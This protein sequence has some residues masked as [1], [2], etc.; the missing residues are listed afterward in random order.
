MFD[1]LIGRTSSVTTV[2]IVDDTPTTATVSSNELYAFDDWKT[3]LDAQGIS[4]SFVGQENADVWA[5]FKAVSG[6]GSGSA[7]SRDGTAYGLE[8][9]QVFGN[10][11][12][13]ISAQIS[14]V[15]EGPTGVNFIQQDYQGS[16]C[17]VLNND[18]H[19]TNLLSYNGFGISTQTNPAPNLSY[20]YTGS[21][22]DP[23][24]DAQDDTPAGST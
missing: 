6:S 19:L 16:V 20:G 18:G 7:F 8:S 15:V 14:P 12:N 23:V 1:N 22:F 24:L 9:Q 10:A 2:T 3:N 4:P 17:A 21:L 5:N 13:S 11:V